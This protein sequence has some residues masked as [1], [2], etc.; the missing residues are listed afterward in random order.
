MRAASNLY[1]RTM[2][3]YAQLLEDPEFGLT[4]SGLIG[5]SSEGAVPI[6]DTEPV[7]HPSIVEHA[8]NIVALSIAINRDVIRGA[9]VPVHRRLGWLVGLRFVGESKT[10]VNPDLTSITVKRFPGTV[11]LGSI[12]KIVSPLAL[13]EGCSIEVAFSLHESK[14][15]VRGTCECHWL[16]EPVLGQ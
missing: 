6:A 15:A 5:L 16:L 4:E 3:R 9:G 2:S 10:F 8:N 12:R 14:F 13:R 7:S 11:S 1:P